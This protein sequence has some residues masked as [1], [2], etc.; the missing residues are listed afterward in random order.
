MS[1]LSLLNRHIIRILTLAIGVAIFAG[2]AFADVQVKDAWMRAQLI[3]GRP[4]AAYF[5]VQNNGPD[6]DRLLS[7]QSPRIGRIELHQSVTDGGMMTMKPLGDVEI[8]AGGK[9]E[10]K[11]GGNHAMLFDLDKAIAPPGTVRMYFVFEKAGKVPVEVRVQAL[12]P[13][14]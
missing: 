12:T 7:I 2:T 6:A 3:S 11:P 4:S 9:I 10:F 1:A 13:K 5:T 14:P 8:P